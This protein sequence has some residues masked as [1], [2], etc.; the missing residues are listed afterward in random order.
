MEAVLQYAPGGI[1]CYS[2]E[3]DE[4][5]SYLSDNMLHFLGYTKREFIKKFDNRFSLMVYEPDRARVLREIAE[6]IAHGPF[7]RCEY[8]IEKKDGALV[9]VHDEGHIVADTNGKRWFYVVIVDI[10]ETVRAQQREREKFRGAMQRLLAANPDAV[11]T[12]QFNLTQNLCDE[13]HGPGDGIRQAL[14][15]KTADE[16]FAGIASQIIG[17]RTR[18]QFLR[19]FARA[20]LLADFQSG[21]ASQSMTRNLP[22]PAIFS[23][24][25]SVMMPPQPLKSASIPALHS[26]TS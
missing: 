12:V 9:W 17:A 1:F 23:P 18:Q 20:A 16:L 7:D 8:Q 19:R 14:C 13:G 26:G 5:F 24:T 11:G 15:A 22:K 4:Q 2:A 21:K 6:Q 3:E 10:T 25:A